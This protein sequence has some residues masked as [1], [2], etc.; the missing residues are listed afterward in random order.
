M[1]WPCRCPPSFASPFPRRFPLVVHM[2]TRNPFCMFHMTMKEEVDDTSGGTGAL[3]TVALPRNFFLVP[4]CRLLFFVAHSV[5]GGKPSGP[6][7]TC[8]PDRRPSAVKKK[9]AETVGIDAT[10]GNSATL[11]APVPS[12]A[13]NYASFM[14]KRPSQEVITHCVLAMPLLH[15]RHR[16]E[17]VQESACGCYIG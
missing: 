8:T 13:N 4:V 17:R 12:K 2:S 5:R 15:A 10:L 9:D 14:P 16:E 7:P 1:P 11:D 6:D 3:S